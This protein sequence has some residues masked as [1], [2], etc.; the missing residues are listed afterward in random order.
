[1]SEQD[2]EV[3]GKWTR[4]RGTDRS[5][6]QERCVK[7]YEEDELSVR[8]IVDRT[9]RSYGSVHRLLKDAGVQF[10]PRGNPTLG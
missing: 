2:E 6:F 5:T 10:R 4:L 7:L 3:I 8:D 9:G 1:M